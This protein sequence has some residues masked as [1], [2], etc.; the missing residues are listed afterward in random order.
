VR[1]WDATTG[2][3]L[4]RQDGFASPVR[5]VA[6][7]W[8]GQWL[9][10]VCGDEK[11]GL[12]DLRAGGKPLLLPGAGNCGLAFSPDSRRIATAGTGDHFCVK[13]WDVST[14]RK[15]F[16]LP[17]HGWVVHRLAFSPDSRRL[18]SASFDGTVKIWDVAPGEEFRALAACGSLPPVPTAL[19]TLHAALNPCIRTLRRH[20]DIWALAFS[21]DAERLACGGMDGIVKIW[22]TNSWQEINT[23]RDPTGGILSLAFKPDGAQLATGGTDGTVKVW[24]LA[25]SDPRRTLYGHRNWVYSVAFNPDGRRL[26]S[27]SLDGTVKIW[28]AVP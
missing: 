20:T 13:V 24:D 22:D 7:S 5:D 9:A 18:A 23:L 28:A 10:A 4:L 6:F 12:C 1:I 25:T 8:D 26:A 27:G 17:G 15:C 19:L 3:Q 2:R 14:R 11:L 21:C 16:N